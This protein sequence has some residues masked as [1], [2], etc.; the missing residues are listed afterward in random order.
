MAKQNAGFVHE[1]IEKVV[2][3]VC[4]LFFVWAVYYSFL[5]GRFDLNGRAPAEVIASVGQAADSAIQTVQNPPQVEGDVKIDP[6]TQQ[7]LEKLLAWYGPQRKHISEIIGVSREPARTQWFPPPFLSSTEL[8]PE[9]RHD[10]VRL[11]EPDVPVVLSGRSA[12]AIA[13]ERPPLK[14]YQPSKRGSDDDA[15]EPIWANWVAVAAQVDLKQQVENFKAEKYPSDSYL[16]LVKVHLQRYD[17]NEPWRGWQ[18]VE[19]YLA[20]E[21]IE[22]PPA[23]QAGKLHAL[24]DTNQEHIA[25]PKLPEPSAGDRI[26]YGFFP[27]LDSPP[28]RSD[29][30]AARRAKDWADRA[31]RALEGRDP[32]GGKDYDAAMVLARAAMTVAGADGRTTDKAKKIYGEALDRVA[33]RPGYRER[34]KPPADQMMPIVAYDLTALPGHAYRYRIRYEAWNRYAGRDGE[35]R[36]PKDAGRAT[37]LSEWSPPS[38]R[39]RLTPDIQFFLTAANVERN[40]VEVAVWKRD[41]RK[42]EAE[43]F[44]FGVGEVI[45][46]TNRGGADFSTGAVCVDIRFN[47][48]VNGKRDTVLVYQM[49]DGVLREAVLSVDQELNKDFSRRAR[50]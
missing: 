29:G 10:L 39:V 11:V 23:A 40:A 15:G 37:L 27:Y 32:Y 4:A 8:S 13:G 20:F 24:I 6:A 38:R 1:H 21:D 22:R 19:T 26:D 47:E 49:P 5:S 43:T 16:N 12:L 9:R 34:N 28:S 14:D 25:R 50:S 48:P 18:D 42:W 36:D 17:E 33:R 3:G 46:G 35:L 44:R 7:A 45:G 41:R 31:E 30:D 2:I